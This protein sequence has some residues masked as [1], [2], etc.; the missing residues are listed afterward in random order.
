M[1]FSDGASV[2]ALDAIR[3]G[4]DPA[5]ALR[6][7][8]G[9]WKDFEID[10]EEARNVVE[11]LQKNPLSPNPRHMYEVEIGHPESSILDLDAPIRTQGPRIQEFAD[12]VYASPMANGRRLYDLVTE[13]DA[14]TKA[15]AAMAAKKL[16]DAGIPGARYKD[17]F[18][19]NGGAGSTSN[20]V[21]YPGS[22]DSIRILRKYGILAPV[23]AAAMTEE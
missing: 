16:F 18:S 12:S 9:A 10:P 1:P 6:T 20:Y 14:P 21:M 11:Y 4:I 2:V 8:R 13:S 7:G 5:E 17:A 19:R 22:E 3:Q 15:E 23:P